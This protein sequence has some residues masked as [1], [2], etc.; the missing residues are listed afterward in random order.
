MRADKDGQD[1]PVSLRLWLFGCTIWIII[2]FLRICKRIRVQGLQN[3]R[4]TSWQNRL[5]LPNHPS[6]L[7]PVLV[8]MVG[9]A[10]GMIFDLKNKF[11]RQTPNGGFE[12][13]SNFSFLKKLPVIFLKTDEHDRPNDAMAIRTI[14]RQLKKNIF[15]I[16][17]EG[18]RSHRS[19]EPK[20]ETASGIR[21][22]K[23]RNGMAFLIAFCRPT[24][25]PVLVKGTDKVLL[26]S[27]TP[28]WRGLL[29][30]L[31]RIWFHK[32]EIVFG[33]P[34]DCSDIL[35]QSR[36]GH[37]GKEKTLPGVRRKDN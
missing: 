5:L 28:N 23:A 19:D 34:L 27:T 25:I 9:F 10:P 30:V 31:A 3:L 12:H 35:G 11:P 26:P 17:P 32:I 13:N 20:T 4:A 37:E 24:L 18:T 33:E 7:D 21:I 16:F 8:P 14:V 2:S 6:M 36:A 22:G 15:I 29:Q 1:F